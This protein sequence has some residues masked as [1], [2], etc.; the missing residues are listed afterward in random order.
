MNREILFKGK[1]IHAMDINEHFNGRWVKGYLSDK[2]YIYDEHL[3]GEFLVDENTICQY[4]GLDDMN[5]AKIWEND[6]VEYRGYRGVIRYKDGCFS[7]KWINDPLGILGENL[8]Y[9]VRLR[10]I[11]VVGNIFDTPELSAKGDMTDECK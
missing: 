11:Q 9:W 4:T 8:A 7:I 3:E 5:N 6:I 10:A 2:N 1:H